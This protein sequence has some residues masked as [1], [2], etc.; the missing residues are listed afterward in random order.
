MHKSKSYYSVK[1]PARRAVW[2]DEKTAKDKGP[3][4]KACALCGSP[5]HKYDPI[6]YRPTHNF[7]D[8]HGP[9]KA[10]CWTCGKSH[11]SPDMWA[12]LYYRR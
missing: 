8:Y 11:Q 9:R 6:V 7:P 3:V 4:I 12:D 5:I 1:T 10:L 2:Y